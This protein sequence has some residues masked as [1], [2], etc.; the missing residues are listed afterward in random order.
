MPF[1]R[2]VRV[3]ALLVGAT[4]AHPLA[5]SADDAPSGTL[6]LRLENDIIGDTDG[7]Y[8]HG[9]RLEWVANDSTTGPEA[10]RGAL[11]VLFPFGDISGGRLGFA[12]GQNI[13]TAEDT[14][15]PALVE[16]DR[17]YAGWLYVGTS[18]S[19]ETPLQPGRN[20]SSF[21]TVELDL[22]IVGPDAYA[23]QVQNGYHGLAGFD[24]ARG[25][26]HQLKNEPAASLIM[27]RTWRSAPLA[28]GPLAADVLPAVDASVGN[29]T[30]HG[31]GGAL[32]RLGRGLDVDYGPARNP[33]FYSP[34]TIAN[35]GHDFAWYVFAGADG[36]VVAHNIFLDGN[37]FADSHSVDRKWLVGDL[38]LGFAVLVSGVK[39]EFAETIRSKEFTEQDGPDR[40]ATLTLS[41]RF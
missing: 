5:A 8:T 11:D 33:P 9:T 41:A 6:S 19:Q 21:D 38:R 24:K 34:A 16:N 7:H 35:P 29:V 30:V 2:P 1:T 18:L 40:F 4:L 23:K 31:G 28:L 15:N 13:Y 10:L 20:F 26:D 3:A 17:P 25:W 37:T 39:I 22:G 14:S 32:L 27:S 12:L 36:R